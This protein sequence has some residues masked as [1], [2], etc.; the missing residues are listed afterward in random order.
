[1]SEH[2]SVD[3]NNFGREVCCKIVQLDCEPI[4]G[5][6][7]AVEIDESKFRKRKYNRGRRVDGVWVFG[8]IECG[9]NKCF[10]KV[11]DDRSADTRVPITKPWVRPGTEIHSDC[12]KAYSQLSKEGYIHK[13][14]NHSEEFVHSE[15]GAYTQNIESRWRVLKKSCLPRYGSHRSL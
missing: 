12:W 7:T 13:T 15:S 6:G 11:V 5:P 10:F 1:M 8:G 2:T 4:G 9:T 14:V 3:W